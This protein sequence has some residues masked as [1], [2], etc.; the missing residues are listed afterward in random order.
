MEAESSRLGTQGGVPGDVDG[1]DAP[2]LKTNLS[3]PGWH[4]PCLP[5]QGDRFK[6]RCVF[7][8]HLIRRAK[9]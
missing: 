3:L 7:K 9:R 5:V 6:T 1:E 2:S 4:A 8:Q